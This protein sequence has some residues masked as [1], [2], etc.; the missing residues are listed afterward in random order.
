MPNSSIILVQLVLLIHLARAS[1]RP[2]DEATVE[3]EDLTTSYKRR[4]HHT[5]T[6]RQPHDPL[7]WVWIDDASLGMEW[8]PRFSLS[9]NG[10]VTAYSLSLT[11]PLHHHPFATTTM[12]HA[13]TLHHQ[14]EGLASNVTYAGRL[15][16]LVGPHHW[17]YNLLN[18]TIT[19]PT[20][21]TGLGLGQRT[22]YGRPAST[23]ADLT[24]ITIFVTIR[25]SPSPFITGGF[26]PP[27]Y[28]SD[29]P[30]EPAVKPLGYRL[31]VWDHKKLV[32]QVIT[33]VNGRN[34]GCE[35]AVGGLQLDTVYK[36][37]V[38]ALLADEEPGTALSFSLDAGALHVEGGGLTT[39]GVSECYSG[40][41][42]RCPGSERC[43]SPYWICDGAPDCPDGVDEVGCDASPC[44]G[45]RCWDDVCI[46]GAWRCDGHR[47]CKDGD[48]EYACPECSPGQVRCPKGGTCVPFNATC[49]GVSHCPDGWDESGA[50]CGFLSC[51]PRELRCLEG[52]RCVEH[53]RLCDGV[54]D[55]P[56]SEDEDAT[57]CTAYT[58]I[59]DMRVAKEDKQLIECL[60]E[61]SVKRINCTEEE[62]RCPSGK[63]IRLLYVCNGIDDCETGDDEMPYA[64][65]LVTTQVEKDDKRVHIYEENEDGIDDM[66]TKEDE[67]DN[68]IDGI[69]SRCVEGKLGCDEEREYDDDIMTNSFKNS[70]AM[71]IPPTVDTEN[72][73]SG[74]DQEI[75][76][77][78]TVENDV[79]IYDISISYSSPTTENNTLKIQEEAEGSIIERKHGEPEDKNEIN[80]VTLAESNSERDDTPLDGVDVNIEV[81]ID[82]APYLDLDNDELD[83]SSI[84][85]YDNSLE[86][87][88]LDT[89]LL[90]SARNLT[91]ATATDNTTS[92]LDTPDDFDINSTTP[93][94][95]PEGTTN[96]TDIEYD[97]S[98]SED[99]NRSDE[100]VSLTS[101]DLGLSESNNTKQFPD[102][103]PTGL[104]EE[105]LSANSEEKD[106]AFKE[107]VTTEIMTEVKI[108]SDNDTIISEKATTVDFSG[109]VI[110]LTTTESQNS[111]SPETVTETE[112]I[113]K[114]GT[115]ASTLR[116]FEEVTPNVTT[117]ATVMESTPNV[118]EA[119]STTIVSS[120]NS[121]DSIPINA[122]EETATN[123]EALTTEYSVYS[124]EATTTM[125]DTL[126]KDTAESITK[127]TSL[128]TE[129]NNWKDMSIGQKNLTILIAV[130][131]E[132]NES[133]IPQYIIHGMDGS[134]Y[135][136]EIVSIVNDDDELS[137]EKHKSRNG[138]TSGRQEGKET[139]IND[140]RERAD[141][142]HGYL[143]GNNVSAAPRFSLSF[144][145][146][147]LTLFPLS[148]LLLKNI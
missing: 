113:I 109:S 6:D 120:I 55:C 118:L 24:G 89:N 1:P 15:V 40:L 147:F 141:G 59:K 47:D 126:S 45:F 121:V 12:Y 79:Q 5:R 127:S 14:F 8:P 111:Q 100:T 11:H 32:S 88:V 20:L 139:S 117:A 58:S 73:P 130:H 3:A 98:S 105:M 86:S 148:S 44:D 31:R 17:P 65:A 64:C 63:C 28:E 103:E 85:D 80:N 37:T 52:G 104:D 41:Q 30:P 97:S 94:L 2:Q 132:M 107:A 114:A 116:S 138:G 128:T 145:P 16:A 51:G 57:F 135:E 53:H 95:T 77:A 70:I 36:A 21:L 39:D 133:K 134:T 60:S 78:N 123:E 68:E 61:S 50:V 125:S 19:S 9:I 131:S 140:G 10:A 66:L 146:L 112:S 87:H 136:Y 54:P 129:P 81:V 25:W 76:Y 110:P 143:Q 48:D 62:F 92:V 119:V 27:F 144:I 91:N 67:S 23:V 56:T 46:A 43:V 108:L 122:E 72:M 71:E 93:Y 124:S 33:F 96:D 84:E 13:T 75:D 26:S 34:N 90:L 7:R 29:D 106:E 82:N 42:V 83:S 137:N 99:Y 74:R 49:D 22:V 4:Q 115:E 142:S 35:A 101:I 69:E 38:E 102:M 18:F